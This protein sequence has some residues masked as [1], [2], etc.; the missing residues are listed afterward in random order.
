MPFLT[1]RD[2]LHKVEAFH[3][4]FGRRLLAAED[5]TKDKE[6][7][8]MLR[9]LGNHQQQL[10]SVLGSVDQDKEY[11]IST[12]KEWIQFDTEVDDPIEYLR[13]FRVDPGATSEE[14]L[15]AA[16]KLDVCLFCLYKSLAIGGSTPKAQRLFARLARM[17][18]DHQ[19]A[20]QSH[21]SYY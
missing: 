7:K 15:S 2:V 3:E 5:T 14:V 18:L 8:L 21:S 1:I 17:E 9:F 6:A 16:N 4:E 20:K 11:K 13:E 10:A 12:L 19:K